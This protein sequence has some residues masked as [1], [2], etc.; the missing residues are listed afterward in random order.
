MTVVVVD[1]LVGSFSFSCLV[2]RLRLR[3]AT[4][5]FICSLCSSLLS[6]RFAVLLVLSFFSVFFSLLSFFL[7]LVPGLFVYIALFQFKP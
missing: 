7:E 1:N 6:S 4:T 3:S 2:G 5:G